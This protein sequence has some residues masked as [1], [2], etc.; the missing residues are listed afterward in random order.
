MG[1][2]GGGGALRGRVPLAVRGSD[3]DFFSSLGLAVLSV[4]GHG[5]SMRG[6]DRP[7]GT[8]QHVQ[9]GRLRRPT[10]RPAVQ[11]P[12]LLP[13]LPARVPTLLPQHR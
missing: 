8:S 7:A 1:Q 9:E 6:D 2:P 5:A 13:A 10:D 11:L 3:R 4:D 12:T